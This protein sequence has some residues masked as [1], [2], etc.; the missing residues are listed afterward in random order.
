MANS[1][2][3]LLHFFIKKAG[4]FLILVVGLLLFNTPLFAQT[5]DYI[6][7]IP[8]DTII[9]TPVKTKPFHSPTRASIYSAIIPGAGQIY[10]RQYWKAPVIWLGLGYSIYSLQKN[11]KLFEQHKKIYALLT[12]TLPGTPS[13]YTDADIGTVG[14]N[15]EVHRRNRDL[16]YFFTGLVYLLNIVEASVGAHLFYFDVG[17]DISLNIQPYQHPSTQPAYGLR[18]SLNF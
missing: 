14:A 13:G 10:N 2:N 16:S 11:V 5:P 6:D 18:L 9:A 3:R 17:E 15:L 4:P 1:Q 8:G 12:D 7:S